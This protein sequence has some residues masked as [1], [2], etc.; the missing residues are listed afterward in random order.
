MEPLIATIPMRTAL[1]HANQTIRFFRR[2]SSAFFKSDQQRRLPTL[3]KPVPERASLGPQHWSAIP[4]A[5]A[6]KCFTPGTTE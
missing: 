3:V 1:D 2:T 6:S 5:P 4:C